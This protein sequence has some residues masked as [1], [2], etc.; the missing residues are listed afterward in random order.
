[1]QV[2]RLYALRSERKALLE[3]LQRLGVVEITDSVALDGAIP[4]GFTRIDREEEAG[5]FDRMAAN[6]RQALEIL[7]EYAP[8]KK[9]MLASFAGRREVSAQEFSACAE[10]SREVMAICAEI[11]A[12][13]KKT[14]EGAAELVRIRSAQAQL[15]PWMRLDVPLRFT[16]TAKTTALIGTLP[17]TFTTEGLYAALDAEGRAFA[18][19]IL[20]ASAEQTCV[21]LLC[22]KGQ[23]Q[24]M[25]QALRALGFARPPALGGGV[26]QEEYAA[27]ERAGR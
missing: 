9:G 22:P 21:F 25:E 12:L 17:G 5:T 18:C 15:E 1:M 19:E 14:A 11:Q 16:G 10:K 3:Q 7:D 27:L 23:A 8:V 6:A 20:S 2:V 4:E 24:E 26:P 13:R